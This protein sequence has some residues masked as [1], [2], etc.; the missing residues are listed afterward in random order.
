[1]YLYIHER[2]RELLDILQVEVKEAVENAILT[3]KPKRLS[4]L[5]ENKTR[6]AIRKVL[7]RELGK[8]PMIM[9]HIEKV[10]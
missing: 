10:A 2:D 6:A 1:M 7:R 3:S 4:E 5:L 9:V 8:D